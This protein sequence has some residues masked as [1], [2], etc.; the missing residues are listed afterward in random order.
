M[1]I[2]SSAIRNINTSGKLPSEGQI[3]DYLNDTPNNILTK[4]KKDE[5]MNLLKPYINKNKSKIANH[6]Y[7]NNYKPN[8]EK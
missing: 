5:I 2:L 6:N 8:P 1:R 3:K 4:N 7:K